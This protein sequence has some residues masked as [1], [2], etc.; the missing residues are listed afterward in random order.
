MRIVA[1]IDDS[2]LAMRVVEHAIAEAER[3]GAD[4]HVVHVFHVPPGAAAGY[5]YMALDVATW[6]KQERTRIWD[7]VDAPLRG[8]PVQVERVDLEGYPPDTLVA[9]VENIGAEL[10]V[11]G[12]RGRGEF[13]SM[14]LGSTSHRAIHLAPCDVLVVKPAQT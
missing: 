4:L 12:T 6:Q 11:V 8:A 1:G 10:L 13:A 3:R 14:I 7:L 2:P 5:G 9:Y